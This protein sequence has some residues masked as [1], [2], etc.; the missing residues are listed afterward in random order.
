LKGQQAHQVIGQVTVGVNQTTALAVPYQLPQKAF[1]ELA[2]TLPRTADDV[3][4]GGEASQVDTESFQSPALTPGKGPGST[5]VY[6]RAFGF[7]G[8]RDRH[9]TELCH[10]CNILS[11]TCSCRYILIKQLKVQSGNIGFAGQS[12]CP[13][14][15]AILSIGLF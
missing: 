14:C 5:Q 13:N 11:P 9:R 2:F 6:L 1:Q 7:S 4:M 12:S 8:Q 15:P 3:H 10:Y